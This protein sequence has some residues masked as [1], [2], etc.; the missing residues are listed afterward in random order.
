MQVLETNGFACQGPINDWFDVIPY[1]WP[2][3][4]NGLSECLGMAVAEEFRVGLVIRK[5]P[6][7]PHVAH[8][9]KPDAVMR[10]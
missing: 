10:S 3:L 9:P 7:A 4:R 2:Y 1:F 5:V 6:S 8:M